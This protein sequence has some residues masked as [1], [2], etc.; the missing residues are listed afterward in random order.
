MPRRESRFR[1]PG[2]EITEEVGAY[3]WWEGLVTMPWGDG[4]DA[5]E[6]TAFWMEHRAAL[7]G[8]Y[9][10]RN[11]EKGGDPGKRPR[12]FWDELEESGIERRQ[13][14]TTR[15]WDVSIAGGGWETEPRFESDLDLII[16]EG[17]PLAAWEL[18]QWKPRKKRKSR[19]KPATTR[20]P[21]KNDPP[22]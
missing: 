1:K 22:G 19:R 17:L 4:K 5:D 14:G 10:E 11:R 13:T 16:R 8:H 20:N 2:A 3:W 15:Y 9:I 21:S 18:E 12:R 6:I 7:I